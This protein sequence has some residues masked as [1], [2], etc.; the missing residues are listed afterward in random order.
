MKLGSSR[1]MAWGGILLG[2]L[3]SNQSALAITASQ[4]QN[5]KVV[6]YH[7]ATE[8]TSSSYRAS[9]ND[10]EKARYVVVKLSALLT[11]SEGKIFGNDFQLVYQ[12]TDGKEDRA[13]CSGIADCKTDS[14]GEIESFVL[15]EAS[16]LKVSPGA[17]NFTVAFAVEADV[18]TVNIYRSGTSDVITI[19]IGRDRK[20]SVY[21]T[22][23]RTDSKIASEVKQIILDG[24]YDVTMVSQGLDESESGTTIQYREKAEA[25]AR[26]IS[27]RLMTKYGILPKVQK[28]ELVSEVDIVV[29]LGK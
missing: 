27:Q 28:M 10:P 5:V 17:V 3:L 11:G 15:G 4:L 8:I 29:W 21:I 20:Y 12:H 24:G 1:A 19:P 16:W 26:E 14:P 2:L 23:N 9:L 6:S 18:E 22:T 7:F 25:A 13:K